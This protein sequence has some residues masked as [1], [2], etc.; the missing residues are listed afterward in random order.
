MQVNK[1]Q[2]EPDMEQWC[3]SKLGKEYIKA[4]YR[5]AVYLTYM[6]NILC[7]IPRWMKHKLEW[8]LPEEISISSDM[9]MTPLLMAESEEELKSLDEGERGEWISWLKTQ[10]SKN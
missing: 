10:H 8:R 5:H 4:V 6:Q 2:L 7:K 3:G 1:Q 9:E